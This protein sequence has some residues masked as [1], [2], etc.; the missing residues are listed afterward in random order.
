MPRVFLSV[1]EASGDQVGAE[2]VSALK[3]IDPPLVIEGITGSK[4]QAAGC[5]SIFTL[6]EVSVSVMGLIEVIS[7]LPQILKIRQ[8]VFHYLIK[9]PPDIFIGIDYTDFNLSVATKL[10]QQ[11]VKTKTIQYKGPSVWAWRRGRI[12]KVKKAIDLIL[13]LFPFEAAPYQEEKIPFIYV[14]H[15]LADAIPLISEKGIARKKLGLSDNKPVMAILPGS[16]QQELNYLAKIFIETAKWCYEQYPELQFAV[17]FVEISHQ[18]L[19]TQ[20]VKEEAPNLP[21]FYYQQQSHLIIEAS[22]VALLTSGTATLESLL[23]KRPMV[24]AYRMNPITFLLAKWLV[25][26]PYIALPNLLAERRLVPEFIQ[27]EVNVLNLGKTLLELLKN[28]EIRKNLIKDFTDIHLKL[29][30]HAAEKAAKA[31]VGLLKS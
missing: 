21:F 8:K 13:T 28:E 3:K 1:G 23:L 14:G 25:K 24:V 2:L 12:K 6:D 15:P 18:K 31:V 20:M 9:N 19:F 4:M 11:N 26:V 29:S 17:P 10:K 16:R 27:E 5:K 22:D 30:C 7:K